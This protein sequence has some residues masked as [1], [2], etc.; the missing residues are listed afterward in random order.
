MELVYILI[1]CL[2]WVIPSL[3]QGT[4]ARVNEFSGVLVE[5]FESYSRAQ[6]SGLSNTPLPIFGGNATI[7]GPNEYI[8]LTCSGIADPNRGC[9]GLGTF[10]ARAHDGNQGYGTSLAFGT[11]AIAFQKPVLRFGGF[12][13]ND[14]STRIVG[15]FF[16]EDGSLIGSD[17]FD[18]LAPNSDGT[19]QWFGWQSTVPIQRFEYSGG[20]IVIDALRADSVPEPSITAILLLAPLIVAIRSYSMRSGHARPN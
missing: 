18:Y 5:D 13:G 16:A 7:S 8:W 20:F 9:F 11:S 4:F 2:L 10:S 14:Q 6:V 12:W 15:Q 19:L 17:G 3:G 1:F